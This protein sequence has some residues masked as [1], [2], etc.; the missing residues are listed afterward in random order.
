MSFSLP[1]LAEIVDAAGQA[2]LEIYGSD[3]EVQHKSD[4]SPLTQADL[5]AHR[6]IE[7]GLAELHPHLPVFSEESEPPPYAERRHWRRYWLVD[8]LDGTREFVN[9]NGEFT[10]NIALIEDG[11][12]RLGLVGAPLPGPTVHRRCGQRPRGKAPRR[13]IHA[14]VR[15]ADDRS[16]KPDRGGQPQPRQ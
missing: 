8:P 4:Q 10:V 14:P 1:A 7:A 5:A 11:R 6:V 13:P 2:I 15:T 16:T 9:R 3:F 12:A